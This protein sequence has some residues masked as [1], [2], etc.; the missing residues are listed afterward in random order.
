VANRV[1]AA[2]KKTRT[3][4]KKTTSGAIRKVAVVPKTEATPE[5]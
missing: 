5:K 4:V 1:T 2:T 3:P